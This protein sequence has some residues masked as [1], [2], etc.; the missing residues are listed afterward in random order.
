MLL[1]A[2]DVTSLPPVQ[3][4]A[5]IGHEYAH[6]RSLPLAENLSFVLVVAAVLAGP[7]PDVAFWLGYPLLVLALFAAAA[8]WKWLSRLSEFGADGWAVAGYG[9][10]AAMADALDVLVPPS[11]PDRRLSW[12]V[13]VWGSHPPVGLRV[14]RLRRWQERSGQ[15]EVPTLPV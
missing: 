7:P 1:L 15:A 5:V 9:C 4:R 3:Q 13:R 11:H 14:A 8:G 10:A 6:L 12:P 2:R